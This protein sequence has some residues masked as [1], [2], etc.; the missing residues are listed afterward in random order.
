VNRATRRQ[1]CRRHQQNASSS[2]SSAAAAATTTTTAAATAADL[3][4]RSNEHQPTR[5][6][7]RFDQFNGLLIADHKA[8][9]R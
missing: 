1:I 6:R 2:S 8:E 7:S 9:G 5:L 4:Y 3:M